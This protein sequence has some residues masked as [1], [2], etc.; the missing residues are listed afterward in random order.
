MLH[1]HRPFKVCLCIVYLSFLHAEMP[2]RAEGAKRYAASTVGSEVHLYVG[3]IMRAEMYSA[4]T[5]PEPPLT[6]AVVP[7]EQLSRRVLYISAVCR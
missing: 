1:T 7:A 2:L 5:K 3:G 6:S 4:A